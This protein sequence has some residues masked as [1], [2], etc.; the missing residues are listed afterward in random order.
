MTDFLNVEIRAG[1]P[2]SIGE[3]TVTPFAQSIQI[4]LPGQI[5]GFIWNRPVSV[6]VQSDDGKEEVLPITDVTRLV[7]FNLIGMSLGVIA[8]IWLVSRIKRKN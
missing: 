7:L 5:G 6:L 4:T 1:E 8:F 3:R 2:V